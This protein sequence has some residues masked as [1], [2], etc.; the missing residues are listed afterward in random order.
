MPF[1][2]LARSPPEFQPVPRPSLRSLV[3]FQLEVVQNIKVHLHFTG[4][5][6]KRE[7]EIPTAGGNFF[8]VCLG[9]N[10]LRFCEFLILV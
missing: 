5:V 4:K 10:W 3:Y 2:G 8:K 7:A 9:L 6:E 1:F